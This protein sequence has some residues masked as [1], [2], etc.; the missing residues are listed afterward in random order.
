MTDLGGFPTAMLMAGSLP[1]L[2]GL[3]IIVRR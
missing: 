3:I 2:F 1:L